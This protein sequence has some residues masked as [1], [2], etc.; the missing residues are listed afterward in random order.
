M[1]Y[2]EKS[3]DIMRL[4]WISP[5]L[6]SLTTHGLRLARA[7]RE[8]TSRAVRFMSSTSA[9]QQKVIKVSLC[10]LQ[11]L[12]GAFLLHM[13]PHLNRQTN[14]WWMT[15]PLYESHCLLL[16]LC[17]IGVFFCVFFFWKSK[18]LFH[19]GLSSQCDTLNSCR[20][21]EKTKGLSL[22]RNWMLIF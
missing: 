22:T 11:G 14:T 17:G 3:S 5:A 13:Q 16:N 15:H 10:L 7:R 4:Y 12:F 18:M 9:R 8:E 21:Q 20:R 1:R 19:I 2:L 6:V